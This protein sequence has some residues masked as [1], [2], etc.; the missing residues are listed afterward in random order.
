[1]ISFRRRHHRFEHT[2]GN[3][4]HIPDFS[5][6]AVAAKNTFNAYLRVGLVLAVDFTDKYSIVLNQPFNVHSMACRG[7]SYG[8]VHIF[9]H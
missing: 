4:P 8:R 7:D 1:M 5:V 2:D 9:K 3:T 6:R